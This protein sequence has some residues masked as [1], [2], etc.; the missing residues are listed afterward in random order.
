MREPTI[1]TKVLTTEQGRDQLACRRFSLRAP[2]ATEPLLRASA[3]VTVGS[4]RAADLRLDD[5]AVSRLHLR[6]EPTDRGVRLV[7]L[8]STNGTSVGGLQ[9]REVLL[10]EPVTIQVGRPVLEFAIDDDFDEIEMSSRARFGELVGKSPAMRSLFA[11]LEQFATTD[12]TVLLLGESGTGKEL[13]AEAVHEASARRDGPFV[14]VD[15]ASLP[16]TLIEGELF[17]HER[18]AYTGASSSRAGAFE[19]AHG[20][21]LFLDEIGEL[22][23]SL[24]PRL[25]RAV[26]SKTVRRIG[27]SEDRR[28]DIRVVAA[29][30]RDLASMVS[31]GDF[32]EDL[33]YRL[34]VLSARLP[35][36]R[37]RRED[38]AML[39][40]YFAQLALQQ[41]PQARPDV[42]TPEV[43]A[44][45]DGRSWPGNV[46]ELKNFVERA[47]LLGP[48]GIL[49]A[50]A[51]QEQEG[52]SAGAPPPWLSLPFQEAREAALRR[53]EMRYVKAAL[54]RSGGNVAAAARVAG[55]HRG[56]LFRLIRRHGL[57]RG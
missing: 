1:M 40:N 56:Y 32:R 16:A 44:K 57:R 3:T 7:D 45:L 46:R 41:Y 24:Q 53:F 50:D 15:C 12:A 51:E 22:E 18:G 37:E 42:L 52:E 17:G 5:P 47:V 35:A 6:L 25:L 20:G 48:R 54:E 9:V 49:E 31:S 26:E 34:N 43:L 11:K 29:T 36:L 2:G 10:T 8:R 55:V 39:A 30:N 13:A 4:S 19:L 33:Y 38:V 28:V 27:G 23:L 21:T 14:V